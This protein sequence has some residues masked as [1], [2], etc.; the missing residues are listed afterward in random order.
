MRTILDGGMGRE[1]QR[2]GA[3][4]RQPEWSALALAESPELVVKAHRSFID[5]GAQVI[6]TNNYA[7]VPFHI[8]AER[9]E[10]EGDALTELSGRLAREAA[11]DNNGVK[12]GGC[13]PPL[14]GSYRADLF[15]AE[16]AKIAY[17]RIV[18]ALAPSVDLWQAETVSCLA[19]ARAIAAALNG[20]DKPFWLAFTLDDDQALEIPVLRSGESLAAAFELAV[21]I[22]AEALLFNCSLPEVIGAALEIV[23]GMRDQ[24][25]PSLRLGGYGN[26]FVPR[27]ADTEANAEF[28][29]LREEV[30]PERYAELA[31]Q[32]EHS[33][34]T[35]I[36]GC[37]GIGPE[38][39]AA[40]S[41]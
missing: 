26:T 34:A 15:D 39:I 36:G 41:K 23:G 6:T 22:N 1:L 21:E 10:N 12:V 27:R 24:A 37:C 20:S 14:S 7:V 40:L 33:G 9:F 8:G 5:A 16:V 25:A 31:A 2:I 19:E 13:L 32:W 4:F 28:A 18:K 30:S 35:L 17:P 11:G 3:P 38:H 29:D